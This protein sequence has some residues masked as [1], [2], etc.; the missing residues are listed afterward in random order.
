[1]HDPPDQRMTST[2]SGR[3]G[4]G[5]GGGGGYVSSGAPPLRHSV[6]F[7]CLPRGGNRDRPHRSRTATLPSDTDYGFVR[8]P[9]AV[10]LSV[11][12]GV[13]LEEETSGIEYRVPVKKESFRD[14]LVKKSVS[15]L[16]PT[17]WWS[18]KPRRTRNEN[19]I[20]E[21]VEDSPQQ[22]KWRSLGA[23]LRLPSS[24]NNVPQAP[25]PRAQSFYL[26]DDFLP[27][28]TNNRR[29]HSGTTTNFSDTEIALA[30]TAVN[31]SIQPS[32]T[33]LILIIR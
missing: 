32:R 33:G 19:I 1:M 6:S 10:R 15:I 26:L 3:G 12:Y 16:S 4:G 28:P 25:S 31:K 24:S 5:G 20:L 2:L 9:P 23:L 14:N 11:K 8:A 18:N 17:A 29:D 22:R 13:M 21:D 30:D 7:S 27:R